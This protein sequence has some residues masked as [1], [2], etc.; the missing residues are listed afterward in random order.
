MLS[1]VWANTLRRQACQ[2]G[3]HIGTAVTGK[4]CCEYDLSS[5]LD[6][7]RPSISRC[8]RKCPS[9]CSIRSRRVR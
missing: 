6:L 3:R 4:A 2:W 7:A 1:C 8:K 9:A 5:G